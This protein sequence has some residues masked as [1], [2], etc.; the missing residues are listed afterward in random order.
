VVAIDDG[1]NRFLEGYVLLISVV[2]C[3]GVVGHGRLEAAYGD[4]AGNTV[5]DVVVD[6]AAVVE[7][8]ADAEVDVEV[9]AA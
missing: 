5:E 9:E 3:W 7:D 8:V 2:S 6:V 1:Q 4:V